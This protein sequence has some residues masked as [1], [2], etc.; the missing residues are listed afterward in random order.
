MERVLRSKEKEKDVMTNYLK[1]KTDEEREVDNLL[2]NHK[3]EKWG[4][5]L[6]KGL[7]EYQKE[8][9]DEER[10]A[11]DKQAIDDMK[12]GESNLVTEMNR[13]IYSMDQQQ[14]QADAENIEKEAF[15]M[16]DQADDDDYGDNDG[17]E[18]Y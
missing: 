2:K 12:L 13:N 6:Q 15:D 1:D 3:L 14:E 16:G 17:D 4:K 8:T 9:Y 10:D 7:R 18:A 5:G 11:M